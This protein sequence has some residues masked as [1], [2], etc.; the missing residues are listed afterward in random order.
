MKKSFCD[1]FDVSILYFC[2]YSDSLFVAIANCCTSVFA[3][4]VIFS[5]VGFMAHEL[6]QPVDTV[7]QQGI[8]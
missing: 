4:F 2:L 6:D 3:G 7:V 5:I 1:M 8:R